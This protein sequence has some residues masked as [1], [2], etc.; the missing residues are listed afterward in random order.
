MGMGAG[1]PYGARPVSGKCVR[2][3]RRR[4]PPLPPVPAMSVPGARRGARPAE[5]PGGRTDPLRDVSAALPHGTAPWHSRNRSPPPRPRSTA[6]P[7]LHGPTEDHRPS[8]H[9]P[10]HT[11]PSTATVPADPSPPPPLTTEG[12]DAS[13]VVGEE[14]LEGHLAAA[15]TSSPPRGVPMPCRQLQRW[16]QGQGTAGRSQTP[17]SGDPLP[18]WG[19]GPHGRG[20]PGG[21]Q[22][23]TS[24]RAGYEVVPEITGVAGG[25][26]ASEGVEALEVGSPQTVVPL[27]PA[28]GGITGPQPRP[29]AWLCHPQHQ[30]EGVHRV[31]C[32]QQQHRR[33]GLAQLAKLG[34]AASM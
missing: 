8:P 18:L 22:A 3:R 17:G 1:H 34:K 12:V 31:P 15:V 4:H 30:V 19:S 28:Q 26:L 33:R 20:S 7:T 2:P 23:L 21:G 14:G 27:Q 6:S 9:S 11:A 32:T 24:A 29:C 16:Q 10:R 13:S 25:H 5:S